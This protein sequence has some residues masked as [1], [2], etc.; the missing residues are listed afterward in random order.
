MIGI[1]LVGI[2]FMGWIHW[3]AAQGLSDGRIVAVCS[4]D[5]RKLAG[6]WRGIQGNFGPPATLVDLTQQARYSEYETL[7][8]DPDV[9]LVDLCVPNNQH[10][11]LAIRALEAGKDVLVEKPVALTTSEADAMIET[12]RKTGRRLMVAH[13]LPFFSEFA[14]AYETVVSGRHGKLRA[15]HFERII[16]RPD[17]SRGIADV[18]CSGGPAID[19]HIHD[20]HFVG[21]ICGLPNAVHSQG[22]LDGQTVVY[23][24][25]Q[26]LYENSGRTV[27]CNSG[28]LSQSGRPFTHGF[29]LYL[30]NATLSYGSGRPLSMILPGSIEYPTPPRSGDPIAAFTAEL[31]AVVETLTT[32]RP[33]PQALSAELA[34]QALQICQAEVLSIR[35]QTTVSLT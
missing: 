2:G 10:A 34:R 14:W 1:G 6:D 20:A 25:T 5:P 11:S 26:Y 9:H 3:L 24:A 4:R 33:I 12:A 29:D 27:T 32:G 35:S 23:L 8:T 28:A 22:V 15:A 16:A 13:V 18:E 19:L 21:L 17:W 30:E 31:E 7:L